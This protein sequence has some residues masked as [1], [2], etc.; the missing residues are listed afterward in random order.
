MPANSRSLSR[1]FVQ[2]AKLYLSYLWEFTEILSEGGATREA[3]SNA[4]RSAHSLKSEAAFLGHDEL[5]GLAAGVESILGRVSSELPEVSLSSGKTLADALETL[6]RAFDSVA[7]A[8]K[9]ETFGRRAGDRPTA[10]LE[11]GSFERQLMREAHARGEVIY[12]LRCRI[13]EEEE[14]EQARRFLLISNLEQKTNLIDFSPALDKPARSDGVFEGIASSPGGRRPI[15]ESTSIAGIRDVHI[16]EL[17]LATLLEA[18]P[19][20][21]L[22]AQ[23][24]TGQPALSVS[25]PS[26]RYEELLMFSS[27]LTRLLKGAADGANIPLIRRVAGLIEE[28]LLQSS[29]TPAKMLFDILRPRI[30]SFAEGLSRSVVLETR[31]DDTAVFV[32]TAYALLDSLIQLVHNA[33]LH[34]IEEPEERKRHG[35]H[36]QG[37]IQVSC[38]RLGDRIVFDVEDDGRGMSPGHLE[39]HY[40]QLFD[41]DAPESVLEIVA[42]PGFST[43]KEQFSGDS[44]PTGLPRGTGGIGLDGIRYTVERLFGGELTLH[45]EPGKGS[46]FTISIPANRKLISVVIARSGETSF[47]VPAALVID[48]L[49][50]QR[51]LISRDHRGHRYIRYD[52]QNVRLYRIE[53][54]Q[55]VEDAGIGRQFAV[56]V[57]LGRNRSAILVD[58]LVSNE[59]ALL[60]ESHRSHVFSQRAG[61]YVQFFVPLQLL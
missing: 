17:P 1:V 52:G 4:F 15:E 30:R 24:A 27:E 16:E 57:R 33:V 54:G 41:R 48:A 3:T 51:R 58:E 46:T 26:R 20:S 2:D 19:E 55:S 5:A 31:G 59:L 56:L 37:R 8:P 11:L 10:A 12:R 39:S 32:T 34:G 25:I 7:S 36:P 61:E 29:E 50:V 18:T 14:M 23:L 21:D 38:R 43:R 35:K 6:Q 40:R 13:E 22:V 45:S 60:D 44:A 53:E 9:Q 28:Y 49:P 47:A 42:E